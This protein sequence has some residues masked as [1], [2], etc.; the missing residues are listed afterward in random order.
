MELP[1]SIA[2]TTYQSIEVDAP[3][4]A[5]L[6]AYEIDE[7]VESQVNLLRCPQSIVY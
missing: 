4:K 5:A 7:S 6:T 2:S 1:L 3:A